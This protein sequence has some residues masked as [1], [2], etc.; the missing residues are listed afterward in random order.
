M[1][2]LSKE[3]LALEDTRE[4]LT[5]SDKYLESKLALEFPIVWA[6]LTSKGSNYGQNSPSTELGHRP[7]LSLRITTKE[8]RPNKIPILKNEAKLGKKEVGKS[9]GLVTT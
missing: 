4:N 3:Q 9:S 8:P 5:N 1:K 2:E 6:A 7:K